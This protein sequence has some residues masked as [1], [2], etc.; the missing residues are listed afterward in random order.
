MALKQTAGQHGRTA[1]AIAHMMVG[2]QCMLRYMRD[3]KAITTE[4]AVEMLGEAW[5]IA[6]QN[7]KRQSDDMKED[8]PSKIFLGTI[9]ELLT[10]K[11]ASVR[12][13]TAPVGEGGSSGGS[14]RDMIGYMDADF[15]YLMPQVAYRVVAKLCNDQGQAFPLTAKMLYKQMREDGVLTA[16]TTTGTS[17]TRPKWID[18]KCQ[19]LLW[20][21]RIHIDGPKTAVEQL[22]MPLASVP[23]ADGFVE[24]GDAELPEEFR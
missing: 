8:R 12:D 10:S 5:E 18:G 6:T 17:A 21:P 19:R 14:G 15:Y 16:E 20:V 1:E 2:Y 23:G 7:S 3:V 9:S 11:A 24:V 22:R 13:L 4:Q